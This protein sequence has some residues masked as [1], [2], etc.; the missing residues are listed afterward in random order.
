[1][2][3]FCKH[4]LWL[5]T[6]IILSVM[7]A[8]PAIAQDQKT[9]SAPQIYQAL[10]QNPDWLNTNRALAPD[11]L[12]GRILLVDFW[13]YCCINCIHVIPKLQ[14]LEA[15]FDDKLIVIGV[16]SAKFATEG[17]TNNIRQAI[18]KYD[19]EHPVVNDAD[20]RIWNAFGVNAWPTVLLIAPNGLLKNVYRGEGDIDEMRSDIKALIAKSG[21]D[22][23]ME[24][25]PIALEKNKVPPTFLRFPSKLVALDD[26][27][28]V[29]SDSGHHRIVVAGLD[30]KVTDIIG[31]GVEGF[32]DGDFKTAQFH[33]PQGVL[34]DGQQIY[35]A[36]T[37]NHRLRLIDLDKKIVT[38]LAGTGVRGAYSLSG[39]GDA[40][41]TSLAS[42]WDLAFYPDKNTIVIANAGTHQLWAYD[43]TTKKLSIVAGSGRE[44]II[45]GTAK[46]AAL[47]QTSG[48]SVRD[49][50]LYFADAETSSLRVFDGA[51]VK[52]LI[53]S[54]LFDFGL[55]DG[56]QG[57]ALMQH[58]IGVYAH[59]DAVY[60]AD[61]YNHKIRKYTDGQ[62]TT[63]SIDGLREPNGITKIGSMFY[64]ADTNNHRIVKM[65]E[66][67]K[68][69]GVL[70]V[71][72]HANV[73]LQE[74]LP[75][76]FAHDMQKIG[77]NAAL[78]IDLPKGWHIN[79][80]APSYLALFDDKAQL[81]KSWSREEVATRRMALPAFSGSA[82]LQGMLYYC[83]D[84]KGSRCLIGGVDL[85]LT[86]GG[87]DGDNV[88]LEPPLPKEK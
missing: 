36:D 33:E 15:E 52:T 61:T 70:E 30:G 81:L 37:G 59:K 77:K 73:A 28:L 34:V 78:V 44:D 45:D 53:G 67:G 50:K 62:L 2:M 20:F 43:R 41:Q 54:G 74:T 56:V 26:K 12:K 6:V 16:H 22:L 55:Q 40:L 10:T 42:P 57:K 39:N 75:N 11:D 7:L 24:K 65:D 51:D 23:V 72:P 46:D 68:E 29:I 71:M 48:L 32:R 64:I 38:T 25:L 49:G 80:D 82:R 79:K 88:T 69:A 31:S 76:L 18:Q 17:D 13:T 85:P 9:M 4:Y 1:M 66:S 8:F 58:D 21:G 27:S 60:V 84:E 14:E 35:V 5:F 19:I 83:Q 47:A 63:L 3:S 86:A 87:A